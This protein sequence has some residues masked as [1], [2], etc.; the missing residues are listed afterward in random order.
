MIQ[1]NI[2]PLPTRS[3]VFDVD[4][5][6]PLISQPARTIHGGLPGVGYQ[7]RVAI[8]NYDQCLT[9]H[10]RAIAPKGLAAACNLADI[11]FD[12]PQFGLIITFDEPTEVAV[13]DGDMVL[14]QSIRALIAQFGAV[15]MRNATIAGAAREKFHRNIFPHLK[16]H[17]D[18]G[19]TSVN[20]YSC[21][22]RDPD[23]PVQSLPRLS[24]T[25]FIANIVAWLE[26]VRT[27]RA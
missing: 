24:S 18:R 8:A 2:V 10:Y 14:D 20:Q 17:V 11:H 1:S 9:R 25:V 23:D 13:H 5:F 3:G 16:F 22:T 12:T 19:P 26:M 4:G 15:S 7:A 27:G 6:K 21:F